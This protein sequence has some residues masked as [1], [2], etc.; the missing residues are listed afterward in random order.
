MSLKTK[1]LFSGAALYLLTA[2]SAF[3]GVDVSLNFGEPAAVAVAPALRPYPVGYDP[4]HRDGDF[5]YWHDHYSERNH[6]NERPPERY[7]TR[8]FH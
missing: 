4:H 8:E 7:P 3:A 6:E 5:K 1:I 2:A